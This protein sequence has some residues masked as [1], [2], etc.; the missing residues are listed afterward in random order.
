MIHKNAATFRSSSDK[1]CSTTTK[2]SSVNWHTC[3]I[4]YMYLHLFYIL[5]LQCNWITPSNR[6]EIIQPAMLL[7]LQDIQ[8]IYECM[9]S[10][11]NYSFSLLYM[12]ITQTIF[13][14]F[15]VNFLWALMLNN[16]LTIDAC[17]SANTKSVMC[18]D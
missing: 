2:W 17:K 4:I 12:Y 15:F 13:Y 16:T 3:N 11:R 9:L 10:W 1:W 18:F 8:S 14:L 6:T 5:E 7:Y